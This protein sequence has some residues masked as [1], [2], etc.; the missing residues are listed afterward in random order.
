MSKEKLIERIRKLLALTGSDYAEEAQSALAKAQI[1][2]AENDLSMTEIEAATSEEGVTEQDLNL[3]KK[4]TADW[5]KRLVS[6][7][8]RS[9]RC[10]V[11]YYYIDN[12][13]KI[14]IVGMPSDVEIAVEAANFALEAATK[15]WSKYRPKLKRKR[16]SEGRDTTRRTMNELKHDFMK[17]FRTGVRNALKKNVE[18]HALVLVPDP[19]VQEYRNEN[20]G[21]SYSYQAAQRGDHRVQQQGYDTGH[22]T[23]K[24][25]SI[26][27]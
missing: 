6:V 23:F 9:F 10:I 4:K 2:M 8:A 16:E 12:G 15:A 17:G 27:G 18:S 1:L 19:K 21:K 25:R 14:A 3:N 24:R 11:F 20:G 26:A 13:S 22:D 7:V 5:E